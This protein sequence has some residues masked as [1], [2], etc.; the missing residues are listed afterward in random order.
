MSSSQRIAESLNLI[1]C[2]LLIV[3]V[4]LSLLMGWATARNV[5]PGACWDRS[6]RMVA[7]R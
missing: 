7:R 5:Q 3:F 2:L 6:D 4:F 1:P